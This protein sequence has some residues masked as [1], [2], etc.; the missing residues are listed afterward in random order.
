MNKSITAL[1]YPL[2][3]SSCFFNFESEKGGLVYKNRCPYP[4]DVY[5]SEHAKYAIPVAPGKNYIELFTIG[6]NINPKKP[7]YIGNGKKG[8][9]HID[10]SKNNYVLT[11]CHKKEL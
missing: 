10:D 1:T 5:I 7:F 11:S 6:D 8:Q 9:F 4:I 2:F 3:L